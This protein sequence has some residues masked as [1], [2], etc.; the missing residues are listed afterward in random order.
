MSTVWLL[1]K[2]EFIERVRQRSFIIATCLGVVLIIGLALIPALIASFAKSTS[3]RIIVATPDSATT[4]AIAKSLE[5]SGNIVEADPGVRPT[6]ADLP[7]EM[8]TRLTKGK[9][10]AALI[11]YRDKQQRLA[12]AYYPKSTNALG[13]ADDVKASLQ[14]A[15]IIADVSSS[16]RDVVSQAL[17]FTF[18]VHSLNARYKNEA[19]QFFSQAI[20]YF[21]LIILYIAVI[22]Y[23]MQVAT[24]VIEEKANRIMEVMIAAARPSQLLAGKIFGISAVALLQ[25]TINAAAAAVASV[26]AGVMY[27]SSAQG[28]QAAMN[29]VSV[30]QQQNSFSSNAMTQGL[31]H[32]PW[33]TLVYLIVFFFLGFFSYSAIYAGIGS[34]LSKPEEVQQYAM[35]FMAPVIAA[36]ILAIFALNFPDLKIVIWGSMIPLISPLLMFMRI[37]T[38]DVPAWQIAVSIGGSLLAIWG[39]TILSGKLYRVGVLMYGKPPRPSEIWRA[40][41]AHT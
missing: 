26:I 23:G 16:Q 28:Q 40:L 39:L 15:V 21:L 18:D 36:Y 31:S 5:K 9:D 8:R 32:V 27:G 11:A 33:A 37:S 14:R 41:R 34:L 13:S 4:A 38:T 22:T 12:F 7:A 29:A 3:T 25:L 17:N 20:V 19:D 6:S 30:A 24:G 10:D 1:I 2:R 35:V